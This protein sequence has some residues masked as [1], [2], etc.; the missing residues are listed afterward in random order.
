MRRVE[1]LAPAKNMEIAIAAIT[2]GADAVYIGAPAFGARQAAGNTLDDISSVVDYAHRYYCKVFVT[3][4]TIL[5]DTELESAERMIWDLYN[6]GVDA[7]IVQDLGVLRMKLP[8]IALHASTQMHNYDIE[9]IKFLDQLGFTRIVLARELTMAQIREIRAAVKAELEV[10]IHGALCVSLSG[11]CYLSHHMSG[12]S[13]NRGECAQ[14]C[15]Q[16]WNVED[17]DGKKILSNEHIL[18]LKD[19]NQ[20]D[21][22]A[23]LVNIGVDSLKIEGRLKDENYVVNVVRHYATH[24]DKIGAHRAAS[25][26]TVTTFMPDIERSFNRGYTNY[27]ASGQKSS[28]MVNRLTP[29]ATGK[30]IGKVIKVVGKIMQLESTE[31]VHN[32]DGLC[33]F[34]KGELKGIRVNIVRGDNIECNEMLMLKPGT[35][36]Y[37]NYDHQFVEQIKKLKS[38]RVIDVDITLFNDGDFLVAHAEDCDGNQATVMSDSNFET[39]QNEKQRERMEQQMSKTG[40]T[41]YRCVNSIYQGDVVLFVPMAQLNE[42]RRKLLDAL[43]EVRLVNRPVEPLFVENVHVTYPLQNDWKLNISNRLAKQFYMDHGVDT[44]EMSF[45]TSA[46]KSKT[47]LMHTRYCIL[48]E[49]GQC[50][51]EKSIS[52]LKQPLYLTNDKH[53]FRLDFDCKRC[54]MKIIKE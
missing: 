13:A 52:K 42:L 11:Q 47:E 26:E 18:S 10:F 5:F 36:V 3:F 39:A 41:F 43:T 28:G 45:E 21:Y 49:I 22:I 54:F 48:K 19:M 30:K 34:D 15:R 32:G 33:Y 14:P 6:I 37:R 24:L 29:K 12:R 25:G 4:N 44:P 50:L 16:R 20:T 53:R 7:L 31:E 2:N 40:D 38:R 8:P 23:E 17:A 9:R 46:Q 1:L 51:K 27:F 35:E